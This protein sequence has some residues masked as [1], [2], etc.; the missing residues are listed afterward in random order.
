[1][2]TYK[3]PLEDIDFVLNDL[4]QADNLTKLPGFEDATRDLVSSI[5]E[6]AAKLC[7]NE[8]QPLNRPGHEEGCHYENGVVRTPKGFKEAYQAY[9]DGGWQG[10]SMDPKYGGQGLPH[11]ITFVLEELL[12]SANMAFAM[13][14]GLTQGAWNAIHTHANDQLKDT[15]LPKM[16]T[17]EWSG[18]MCL[19]EP[20]CGTDL[21]LI[22]TKAVPNDDGSY[23]ITGTKIFISAGEH[24]L[25]SNIIHLVL[26]KLPDAPPGVKGIS[27][28]LVPKFL[29]TEDNQPGQRN[30]V[31]CGSIEHKMG[32]MANATC[33]MNFDDAKGWLVGEPHKGM[34]AMFTMMNAARLGVGMQGLGIATVAYQNALTY[35]KERL[36]GRSLTGAKEPE[37]AADPLI[38]H[39]DV[40]KNLMTIK[41]F[42]EGARA[43]GYWVGIQL[44]QADHNPDL[45]ARAEADEFVALLTPVVKAYFTDMGYECATMAQQMYGG[46]GYIR[47]W[48]MEQF[49]RD[50]RIAMIYE[51]A[52]GI[53]ALDL[54]GRKLGQ[55]MGRLLRRFFHPL[56][57]ELESAMEDTDLLE[58]A[59]PLAKAF[60]KLQQATAIVAQRGMK[61]P[62]EAGAASTDY[63]RI[64]G[65]VA[66]GWMWLRMVKVANAKLAEGGN[67]KSGFYEAKIKTARFFVQ[68]LLPEVDFRF[69][70]LMSG[71]KTVM[72]LEADLF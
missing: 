36:Q 42:T 3:A 71:A 19:T 28:F 9:V 54:V 6:E 65:L 32:I 46:H 10:L 62:D 12:I 5:L 59:G 49:V 39:P 68:R 63:L 53:Q 40:R 14:P 51:G 67:G 57:G 64:F 27:L 1:M 34:R 18:T 47:E 35:T 60:G 48:G 66:L 7:E 23:S 17:G 4:L 43:L 21:G 13:Y 72:D 38:V 26:A 24:D 29:P 16:T 56:A 31:M 58:F 50:A 61:N 30:G 8:L 45:K 44:D 37:K 25:T 69:K 2:P 20:H 55:D 33:V 22:K 70:A 41:A 52:N 15:Y 11:A